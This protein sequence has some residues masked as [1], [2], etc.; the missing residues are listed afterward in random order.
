MHNFYKIKAMSNTRQCV[1]V[2]INLKKTKNPKI[3]IEN[4]SYMHTE[5]QSDNIH[6][7]DTFS[8]KL[9]MYTHKNTQFDLQPSI[10]DCL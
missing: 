10:V 4:S 3:L 5:T 1:L 6:R 8:T 7:A 2:S 9:F